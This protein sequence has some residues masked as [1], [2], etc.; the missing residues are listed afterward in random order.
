MTIIILNNTV[1]INIKEFL[2][3][4]DLEAEEVDIF[5]KVLTLSSKG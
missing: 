4:K 2:Y 5:L 3:I 1:N